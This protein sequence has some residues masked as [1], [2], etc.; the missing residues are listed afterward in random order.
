MSI[1]G[2]PERLSGVNSSSTS[3]KEGTMKYLCLVYEE[4]GRHVEERVGRP[5]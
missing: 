3:I 4:A 2:S 1:L 5:H